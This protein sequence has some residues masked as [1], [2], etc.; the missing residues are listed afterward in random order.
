MSALVLSCGRN[1][2]NMM[3]EILRGSSVLVATNPAEDKVLFRRSRIVK[4]NYLSKCDTTYINNFDQVK[5]TLNKNKHLKIVWM[6]RDPRDCALSKIYRGQP[7]N[8]GKTLSDDATFDGCLKSIDWMSKVYKYI[9]KNFSNRIILVKMEDIILDFEKTVQNVCCFIEVNYEDG[10]RDFTSR[11]RVQ[12]KKNRY[13]NIDKG[14]VELYK[15][16]SK[17]YSGFYKENK[18]INIKK[19][20]L[21]LKPY[22]ELFNYK[23]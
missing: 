15:R 3:L 1:G 16:F 5:N 6:V 9:N 20:F 2:T 21:R 8:D 11:Y 4:D 23:P 12:S 18:N 19:L 17:I 13:K 22:C 7:G 14:Q 10:M